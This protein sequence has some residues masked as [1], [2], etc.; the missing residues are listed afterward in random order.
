MRRVILELGDKSQKKVAFCNT[1]KKVFGGKRN[2]AQA[3]T[4]GYR[5]DEKPG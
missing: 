3:R 2:C 5:R 1:L 4:K